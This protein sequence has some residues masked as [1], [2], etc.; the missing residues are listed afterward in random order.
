LRRFSP[1][2]KSSSRSDP[3]LP[4]PTPAAWPNGM[5]LS[6]ACAIAEAL[7]FLRNRPGAPGDRF[8]ITPVAPFAR[9]VSERNPV[10]LRR[11]D[12]IGVWHRESSSLST[13]RH[14]QRLDNLEWE[15]YIIGSIPFAPLTPYWSEGFDPFRQSERNLLIN[16]CTASISDASSFFAAACGPRRCVLVPFRWS[17][18]WAHGGIYAVVCWHHRRIHRYSAHRAYK[19][20]AWLAVCN[21]FLADLGRK[22]CVVGGHHRVHH[23]HAD[24]DPD[25]HPR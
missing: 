8:G 5:P 20:E 15:L 2:R 18:V 3:E 16:H 21:G 24:L 25:I 10:A 9:K 22:A 14:G 19:L 17:L 6:T 7:A 11:T 23:R 13:I 4:V 12:G 1:R